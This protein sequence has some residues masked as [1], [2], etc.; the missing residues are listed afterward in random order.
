MYRAK[1]A[2]RTGGKSVGKLAL[3]AGLAGVLVLALAV[4]AALAGPNSNSQGGSKGY[5]TDFSE[6]QC[7]PLEQNQIELG[8]TIYV[9]LKVPVWYSDNYSHTLTF[10]I[11]DN[12]TSV[13]G[14]FDYTFYD[15]TSFDGNLWYVNLGITGD[16]LGEGSYTLQV[17]YKYSDRA[18]DN[19]SSD[20]FLVVPN[21]A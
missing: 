12:G 5:V 7:S 11:F 19:F 17:T 3:M 4:P 6:G 16:T 18:G 10:E 21:V 8:D 13:W 2:N 9:D 20:S 1:H 15:C 14:P